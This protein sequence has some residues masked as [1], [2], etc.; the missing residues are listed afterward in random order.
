MLPRADL[1]L[2]RPPATVEP[3]TPT[4][5]A[6]DPGQEV[7]RRLNQIAIGRELTATVTARLDDGTHLVKVADAHARMALPVGTKVGD[8]LLLTFLAREPRPTFLLGGQAG[9]ANAT[10]SVAARL[11]DQLLQSAGQD[12]ARA[13]RGT[14][15]LLPLPGAD[16]ARLAARLQQALSVSG[17]F[18]ESHLQD[19]I[20]GMRSQAQL[21]QEPQARLAARM[22]ER[23]NE[24]ARQAGAM[25]DMKVMVEDARQVDAH[26]IV[27]TQTTVPSLDPELARLLQQQLGALEQQKIHW[28]GQLWPGQEMEWDIAEERSQQEPENREASTWSSVVRFELPYLGQVEARLQLTGDR[29]RIQVLTE[30]E[31]SA[32]ALREFGPLLA[33]S[34]QDAGAPLEAFQVSRGTGNDGA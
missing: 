33:E 14:T 30:R 26:L 20:N 17:L 4:R 28:R 13:V 34:L 3:P 8:Q 18:Y 12:G 21:A 31:H 25:S 11:I 23:A 24:Q 16:A 5:S 6:T 22:Q 9:S 32:S 1:N 10:I 2:N 19:W 29:V 7:L 27:R 15:P